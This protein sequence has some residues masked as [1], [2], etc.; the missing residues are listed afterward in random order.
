MLSYLKFP[1]HNHLKCPGTFASKMPYLHST[2]GAYCIY[3]FFRCNI[4]MKHCI[5]KVIYKYSFLYIDGNFKRE[6]LLF[7]YFKNVAN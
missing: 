1:I 2:V 7:E 4:V 6:L 3:K 5:C